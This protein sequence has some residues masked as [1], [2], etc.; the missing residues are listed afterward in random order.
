MKCKMC[1]GTGFVGI[2]PGIRGIKRCDAC[3]G[4]GIAQGYIGAYEPSAVDVVM[5]IDKEMLVWLD[6][7]EFPE[8]PQKLT[9]AIRDAVYLA[10][11]RS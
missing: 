2:G 7:K 11:A 10:Y 8:D 1:N 6:M 4:T 9:D 3:H 5:R